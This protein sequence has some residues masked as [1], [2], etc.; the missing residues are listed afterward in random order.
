MNG[1]ARRFSDGSVRLTGVVDHSTPSAPA[2]VS[3]ADAVTGRLYNG[4]QRSRVT[5]TLAAAGTVL[6]VRDAS[7]FAASDAVQVRLDDTTTLHDTTVSSIDTAANTVTLS[8]AIPAGRNAPAGTWLQKPI[9]SSF[10]M[11][12][13]Y[14]TPAVNSYDWGFVGYYGDTIDL[15]DVDQVRIEIDF[16]GGTNKRLFKAVTVPVVTED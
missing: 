16:D 14:G 9:G 10:D 3:S 6:A 15:F 12:T 13:A 5:A 8:A 7:L 4:L 2:T 1:T 11:N